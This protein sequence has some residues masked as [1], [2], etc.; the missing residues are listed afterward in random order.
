MKDSQAPRDGRSDRSELYARVLALETVPG[1]AVSSKFAPAGQV[2]HVAEPVSLPLWLFLSR[3]LAVASPD[4]SDESTPAPIVSLDVLLALGEP[5]PAELALL[6]LRRV[7]A[8]VDAAAAAGTPLDAFT[9]GSVALDGPHLVL[10]RDAAAHLDPAYVDPD[11]QLAGATGSAAGCQYGLALLAATLLAGGTRQPSVTGALRTV[12]G[13]HDAVVGHADAARLPQLLR[14]LGLP[15]QRV[16][17][18]GCD[19]DPGARFSSARAFVVALD[20]A[21]KVCSRSEHRGLVI[22]ARRIARI[23]AVTAIA[24]LAGTGIGWYAAQRPAADHATSRSDVGLASIASVEHPASPIDPGSVRARAVAHPVVIPT[25]LA[26]IPSTGAG[27]VVISRSA[28]GDAAPSSSVLLVARAASHPDGASDSLH[29]S[30]TRRLNVP[31]AAMAA[32]LHALAYSVVLQKTGTP[33]DTRQPHLVR[34]PAPGT[35]EFVNTPG[36]VDTSETT[37]AAALAS[38]DQPRYPPVLLDARIDGEVVARFV[39]DSDGKVEPSTFELVR[40]SHAAFTE[41]VRASLRRLRYLP[42]E[43]GGRRV[44]STVEQTFQFA[45]HR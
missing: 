35:A 15:V 31:I 16:L 38:S 22:A 40:T 29:R 42:A 14:G 24:V 13:S 18:T 11:A 32:R 3:Q 5:W 36:L 4:D 41:A 12:R 34:Q 17:L 10:V 21:W 37:P 9:P 43:R 39:V 8:L 30:A 27:A 26:P 1:C 2:A 23:G 45:P 28:L 20:A 44:A 33:A 7:A 19:P 25:T 6:L